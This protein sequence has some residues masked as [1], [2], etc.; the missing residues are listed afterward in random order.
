VRAR[1]G[2]RLCQAGVVT[3][4]DLQAALEEHGRSGER[5]GSVLVRLKL[6]SERQIAEALAAQLDL[7]F[8]ELSRHPLSP[9]ALVTIPRR[10]A[11]KHSCIPIA[12]DSKELTVAMSDPLLFAA[13][14][15][16]EFQTSC[17]IRQ[18]VATR[19]DI[20]EAIRRGYP[21]TALA[22][23][24]QI[25]A[26]GPTGGG[27]GAEAEPETSPVVKIVD[28]AIRS[29]LRNGASDVHIEPTET[30]VVVR[31]RVDG[32]L[33]EVMDLPKWVHE[34]VVARVKVMAGLDIAEK[35]LPQDGRI[36]AKTDTG[37]SIDLRVSTL[38]TVVG[39]KIVLRVL[40]HRKGV[41]PLETLGLAPEALALIQSFLRHQHGMILVVGP[42]GSGKTTTL[43]SALAAL[44]SERTNIVT[45]ED[46]VEYQIPGV[47]QT[48]TNSKIDLTFAR[49]LRAVLRQDPDVVLVGEIRD[50]DT[51]RVAMQAAQTGHLVL[52]T[53]HTNDAPSSVERL[54][55]IGIEPYVSASALVGIIAQ[56]LL[57]RLCTSCRL[58]Y[59]PD[60][61]LLRALSIPD[62]EA[63]GIMFY[64]AGGCDHC[65]QTGYRG[66]IG[67]YEI[68]PITDD[69]RRLISGRATVLDLRTSAKAAGMRTLAE[70]G[71]AKVKAGLTTPE[72]LHRVVTTTQ[73]RGRSC[74]ACG[75][76]MEPEYLACPACGHTTAGE[77]SQCRR[78]LKS[79]WNYCPF[80]AARVVVAGSHES[81]SLTRLRAVG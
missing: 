28:L 63:A 33:K 61:A 74:S 14:Q 59:A 13:I 44:C 2:E 64:R 58:P 4:S 66:R 17:R 8:V 52:S 30:A 12:I 26:A 24:V 79:G 76:A 43:S 72:E 45:I 36:R 16:L 51:A 80:C 7:P 50:H 53:L 46:P 29:A 73:E 40:D 68:M 65:H 39:E 38:R 47:N 37:Q 11:L 15:D 70:D 23:V 1:I 22:R 60:A 57:R 81:G 19:E 75:G 18:V 78:P 10:I 5:L 71:V 34:G 27:A 48:Q 41:P 55:D 69:V 77:C 31:Q 9:D 35:R 42:T 6:V 62:D 20:S 21:D 32:L 67:I 3:H 54:T 25:G 56:R 49:S